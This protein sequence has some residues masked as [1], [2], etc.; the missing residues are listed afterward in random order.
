MADGL[1][2]MGIGETSWTFV[3]DDST[4]VRIVTDVCYVPQG[5]ARLLS[6]Q[7]ILNKQRWILGYHRGDEDNFS[8]HIGG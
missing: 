1:E 5:K 2:V 4:E 8:L 3:A 6:T 7:R